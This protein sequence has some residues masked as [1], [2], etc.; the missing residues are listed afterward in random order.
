MAQPIH[1]GTKLLLSSIELP[2]EAVLQYAV[3]SSSAPE[4]L[5]HLES[6]RRR[7]LESRTESLFEAPIPRIHFQ[8]GLPLL[9]VFKVVSAGEETFDIPFGDLS[10]ELY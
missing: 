2:E 5:Q 1:D 10:R 6:A 8:A 3:Y 7:F 4:P 9:Y